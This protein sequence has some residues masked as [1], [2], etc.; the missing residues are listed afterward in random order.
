M[1]YITLTLSIVALTISGLTFWL[2]KI[3][4]GTLKMTRPSI[5]CFLGQ[6][7]KDE[8]KVF[9]RTLLY[10][11]SDQGQYVQ[12][13]FI[14]LKRSETIQNFNVWAYNDDE[15]VRGS[16][17]FVNKG[18]VS[19]YH[20]FLLPKNE[21]WDFSAGLYEL[22]V[23]AETVNKRPKK[24]FEQKLTLNNEQSLDLKKGKAVYFDWV[25][26]QQDYLSHVDSHRT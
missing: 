3:R 21:S 19:S 10:G 15:L 9:I 17:L 25:P 11:T 5:I 2:T 12:N 23:F 20:H 13:M 26:N 1:E 6:N 22:E 4:K 16:G 7:G 8:P 18:G 24:I 14:R